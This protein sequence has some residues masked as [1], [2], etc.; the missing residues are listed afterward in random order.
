M[1]C[2]Y[3]VADL[4]FKMA[5]RIYYWIMGPILNQFW[6]QS[7]FKYFSDFHSVISFLLVW[8]FLWNQILEKA[9]TEKFTLQ[10]EFYITEN[11]ASLDGLY[12]KDNRTK[13]SKSKNYLA[14]F[15]IVIMFP[16]QVCNATI[17]HHFDWTLLSCIT[18]QIDKQF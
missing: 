17:I 11:N 16:L 4:L 14:S 6:H 12:C 18:H 7:L 15:K 2:C 5:T 10:I 8:I 1:N 13:I 3:F 9:T